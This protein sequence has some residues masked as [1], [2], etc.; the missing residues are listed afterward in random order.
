MTTTS[1]KIGYEDNLNVSVG[2]WSDGYTEEQAEQVVAK[3][4][5][6]VDR[7]L[8]ETTGDDSISYEPSTSEVIY[9]CDGRP[10]VRALPRHAKETLVTRTFKITGYHSVTLSSLPDQWME[11][12]SIWDAVLELTPEFVPEEAFYRREDRR[13]ERVPSSLLQD[14]YER[15]AMELV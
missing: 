10:L 7:L 9:T 3:Y 5:E 4:Y 6:I 15:R 8:R 12:T 11:S 1:I 13:W 2:D 14:A